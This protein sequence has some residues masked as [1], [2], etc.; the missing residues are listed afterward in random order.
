M[1]RDVK[2]AT[3]VAIL[4]GGPSGAALATWLVRGGVKVALFAQPKRPPIL[5]G[6]SLVPA[7]VPIL[8]DLGV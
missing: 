7:I 2:R 8:R 3:T 6:E 1:V 4:G 5:I